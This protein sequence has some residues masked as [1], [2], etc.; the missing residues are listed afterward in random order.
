MEGK[1]S[2][3]EKEVEGGENKEER[4]GGGEGKNKKERKGSGCF[5]LTLWVI[6]NKVFQFNIVGD[7]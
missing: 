5:S 7:L 4:G 2:R 1:K 6:C 3:K